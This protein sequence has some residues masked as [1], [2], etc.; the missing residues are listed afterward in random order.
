[1]VLGTTA[2]PP[3]R[4][5]RTLPICTA[6]RSIRRGWATTSLAR[7]CST[8]KEKPINGAGPT[9]NEHDM[10]TGSQPDGRAYTDGQDHTCSNWT[11]NGAGDG[12]R[13][14]VISIALVAGT[15]HGTRLTRRA[16]A[17][18]PISSPRAV[19]ESSTA[20]RLIN[21]A[22]R[23]SRFAVRRFAW[24]RSCELRTANLRKHLLHDIDD[25]APVG[26]EEDQ[27]RAHE[28]VLQRVGQ[29]R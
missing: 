1:M 21:L 23:S 17:V 25:Q 29:R 5:R 9:P 27:P 12:R 14:S 26:V 4:L 18:S 24:A 10:L 7:R 28:S 13:S 19:R 16:A 3:R 22:V 2:R 8:K 20:S 6:T 11:S 15:R